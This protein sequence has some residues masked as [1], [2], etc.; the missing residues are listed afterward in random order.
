MKKV[1]IISTILLLTTM[2]FLG[3]YNVF[4]KKEKNNQA[5]PEKELQVSTQQ[6][7][8]SESRIS[9]ISDFEVIGPMVQRNSDKITYYSR[10]DGTVWES[11][12]SGSNKIKVEN[13][14]LS[15]LQGVYWSSTGKE[16][17]SEFGNGE[18]HY[19]YSFD[20]VSNTGSK[21][22]KGVDYVVWDDSGSKMVYKFFDE[23][24][25]KR[26]IVISKTDGTEKTTL[27][28]IPYYKVS[29]KQIPHTSLVAY[30]N[31]PNANEESILKTVSI[32]G[33]ESKVIFSGRY[34][35]DYNWSPDGNS[36][37]V[38]SLNR[39]GGDKI[40]LGVLTLRDGSYNNIDIPTLAE[41]TAWSNDGETI[42]YALPLF[43]GD[44]YVLPDDYQKKK[45]S[46]LDT[47]W[48]VEVS[49]GRKERLVDP[50]QLTGKYDA[51]SLM[52]SPL[53]DFLFFIN[54]IDGRLY[55]ISLG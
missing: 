12:F 18:G 2:F 10:E 1:F 28:E 41:K 39:V 6:P 45:V 35:A 38:S 36:A 51:S 54:R 20:H 49:T 7:V 37:I 14:K 19:F 53:G 23:S 48:K 52:L 30:W 27:A 47:F 40:S 5:L 31:Y 34:G 33:G 9:S 46:T 16:S 11:D 25:K 13:F 29:I 24:T 4:S 43:I 55:R 17:I 42:Y 8:Q 22:G 50:E 15:G 26:S 21:L 44:Q 3:I 32:F